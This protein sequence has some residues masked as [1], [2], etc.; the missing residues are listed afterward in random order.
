MIGVG[1]SEG[2]RGSRGDPPDIGR[3]HVLSRTDALGWLDTTPIGLTTPEAEWRLEDFGRNELPESRPTPSITLLVR[4]FLSP[5]IGLLVL[6]F[7]VTAVQQHWADASAILIV[8]LLNAGIGF[9]Q[10][11]RAETAVRAL[12]RLSAPTCRVLR[13][14]V[15]C[16]L[17]GA[18]V[19]PGDIV[20]L[21]SG[22]RVAA[23]LRLLELNALQIDES[24]LTG[25]VLPVTKQV[26]RLPGHTPAT[27]R[28]NIAFTGTLVTSGRGKGLVVATGTD[29]ELGLINELVQGPV[30]KTPLQILAHSLER[31]I[32]LVVAA[33]CGVVFAVGLTLGYGVSDMFRTAVALAVASIPE[34]LPIVLTVAMSLGVARMARHHAIV[35]SLT[36]VETLGSTTVIGSDKTGTLTCNEL[37]VVQLWTADG[38]MTLDS[39]GLSPSSKAGALS[40]TARATLRAGALTNEAVPAPSGSTTPVGDPLDFIGDAVDVAM[41]RPAMQVGLVTTEARQERWLAHTPYEPELRYSQTLRAH[42]SSR[43]LYVKGSPDAL[44]DMCRSMAT[45]GGEVSFNKKLILE[46]NQELAAEGMRVLGVASRVLAP[47]ETVERPLSPP[48]GLTFLGL[49]AME[50]PPRPGVTEAVAACQQAGITVVMITGD[51][52]A[53]AVSIAGRLGLGSG[54][55]AV[56]GREMEEMDDAIL[57]RRLRES[58]VAARVTPADKLRIVRALQAEDEV[59]AVTGD[60]VNDAPALRA[61]SIGVA[62]GRSGTAVAREAADIVLTDDNFV[63]IVDAVKQGRVTFNSIRNATFFLLASGLSSLLAVSINLIAEQPLL[64]LPI[65]LLFINVVTNGLQDIALAFEPP[66]GDELERKPRPVS[67]GLLSRSLWVRTVI[68]G[69]WMATMILVAFRWALDQGYTD[70]QAR[71]LALTLFVMLNFWLVLSART[72]YRSVFQVNPFSNR[73]LITS[74]LGALLIYFIATQW[75]VTD[76]VLGLVALSPV[77]WV[78]CWILGASILLI[79][80]VD[81][82]F[83]RRAWRRQGQMERPRH[84]AMQ[85]HPKAGGLPR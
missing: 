3:W 71:T 49:E 70:V 13:D 6:A 9:W 72:A 33:A 73:L 66:E 17:P 18:E 21:E 58:G 63:T 76:D 54:A 40:D 68:A 38:R 20:L 4:Q 2:S 22:E 39:S 44:A 11:R 83:N 35:R 69:M 10:E 77:Q 14:G 16:E 34:S 48:S 7:I 60:G 82:F 41:L 8:L 57:T 12:Q 56:T 85:D 53:T 55:P 52:P 84:T 24:M 36:A 51:H 25:E 65:Q 62:M 42:G 45:D 1:M 32:G 23:D 80:E 37:T 79:V 50:D 5:L 29:T 74:A 15:E 67:E 75:S 46:A 64:F 47:D 28:T 59:V 27:E 31:R 19:A 78:A 81:K 30:G 61:A 26:H 43:V